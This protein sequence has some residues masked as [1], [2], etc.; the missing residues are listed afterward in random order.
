[1]VILKCGV[2]RNRIVYHGRIFTEA[3]I[4]NIYID[5]PRSARHASWT[6]A[7]AFAGEVQVN[8]APYNLIML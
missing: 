2:P 4:P 6:M 8:E 1:V 3:V 7:R 5:H